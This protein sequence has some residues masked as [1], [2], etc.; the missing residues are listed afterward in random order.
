MIVYLDT[1]AFVKLVLQE[2]GSAEVGGWFTSA[3]FAASSVITYPESCAAI[4]RRGRTQGTDPSWP[5]MWL[6]QL[7]TSWRRTIIIP[8]LERRAG[9]LALTH[10][11]RGMDAVHLAAALTLREQLG[12]MASEERVAFAAFDRRLL[13]AAGREGFATLGGPLD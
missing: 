1:S 7:E 4:G 6:A 3:R 12:A 9:E 11:L 5:T 2:P 10:R 8:I 13:E